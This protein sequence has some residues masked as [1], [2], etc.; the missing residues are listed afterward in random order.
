MSAP[1]E[2]DVV[3]TAVARTPFGRFRGA[4]AQVDHTTLGGLALDR[5][6]S[7]SGVDAGVVDAVYCGVGMIAAGL[8]SPVRQMVL[9]AALPDTVPSLTVDRACCSGMTA[10]GLGYK[11]IALGL[12]D[13]V[14]CGG[15]E[16][17]STTPLLQTRN[18]NGCEAPPSLQDPLRLR[19]PFLD[20]AIAAYTGEEALRF[21]VGRVEQ[22][23]WALRSHERY[24]SAEE[25]GFFAFE[26]EPFADTDGTVRL[27]TDEG[28]RAD[29]SH[30]KLAAL[31]TV[32]GSPTVTAGNAPG[33]NDGAA[34][35]LLASRAFA[36]SHGLP[37]LARIAA[38]GQIAER[39]TS[40]SYAPALAI[41]R[42]LEPA[43]LDV[44]ELAQIEINEAFAATPL[45]SALHLAGHDR[46][47]AEAL[48]ERINPNG[49]AVAIGHPLGASGAR[50]VMTLVAG[51]RAGGGGLGAAAICGGFGQGDATLV[52]VAS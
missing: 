13:C 18:D 2:R 3:V 37:V 31:A 38:Y 29:T 42:L 50:L 41:T 21:G 27:R 43:S 33:L 24:F 51:L 45:V 39:P 16:S 19:A 46:G 34:F 32:H 35:V 8:L 44:G 36:C 25:R 5:L 22:D 11:D 26:R 7:R 12:A 1:G 6:L 15:V 28:P 49:G 52:E 10:I 48:H 40:G 20:K 47:R 14:V 4:L 23:A 9:A 17:L 30:D